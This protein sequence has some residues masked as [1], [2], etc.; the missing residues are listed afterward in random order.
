MIPWWHLLWI[1]PVVAVGGG[2]GF[3]ILLRNWDDWFNPEED[4]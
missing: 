2:V 4:E 3:I 1:V